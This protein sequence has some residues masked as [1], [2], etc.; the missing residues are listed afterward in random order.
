[1]IASTLSGYSLP[2]LPLVY[3]LNTLRGN[4]IFG[5]KKYFSREIEWPR[6][7]KYIAILI[8][9]RI[10]VLRYCDFLFP[11]ST[12]RYMFDHVYDQGAS[13]KRVYETTASM[14][15]AQETAYEDLRTSVY[16]QISVQSLGE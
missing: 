1:M 12:H 11:F 16:A 10:D 5:T 7:G 14:R 15:L 6:V 13:Q 3:N 9:D 8:N 2:R 4:V